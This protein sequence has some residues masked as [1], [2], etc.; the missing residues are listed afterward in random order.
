M[1]FRSLPFSIAVLV[2]SASLCSGKEWCS[3]VP[4]HSTRVDV[5][6]LLGK[7]VIHGGVPTYE[8]A[9]GTISVYYSKYACGDKMNFGQWNVP[10]DTVLTIEV[11]PKKGVRLDDLKL[12]LK[13]FEKGQATPDVLDSLMYVDKVHGLS[14]LV[15]QE[16]GGLM[17]GKYIYWASEQDEYLHCPGYLR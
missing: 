16:R 3:I 14:L 5:E 15:Y 9:E 12:D 7:P 1:H 11:R 17:V 8:V 6:R 13:S 10:P 4:L 2:V